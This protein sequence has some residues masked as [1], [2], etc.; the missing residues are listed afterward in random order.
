MKANVFRAVNQFGI[1]EVP[2]LRPGAGGATL[3]QCGHGSAHEARGGW[4]LG[5]TMQG[6]HALFGDRCD[7]VIEVA[8][9]P[10]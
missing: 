7:G 9:R 4:R 6:S 2:H 5:N 8:S 1:E 10:S 3:A